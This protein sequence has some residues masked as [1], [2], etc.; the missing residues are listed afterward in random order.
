MLDTLLGFLASQFAPIT[1]GFVL[2]LCTDY[3]IFLIGALG[4]YLLMSAG[5]V[6]L[7]HAALIGAAAYASGVMAVK[8]AVPLWAAMPLAGLVGLLC[9]LIYCVLLGLRLGGFYLAI[10]TFALGE[11]MINI[12]LNTDYLGGALG[13][14]GIPMQSRWP[15]VLPVALAVIFVIWRLENSRF[16]LAFRAIRDHQ[17]V[18]GSMGVDVARMKMTVWM[19]AGFVTGLAGC[20]HAHRV[21]IVTPTEF[22]IYT[23]ITYV[24]AP[25]LGGLRSLWGTVVG[26]AI[27]YFG[28]WL[29]TTDDPRDRLMFYGAMLVALMV[30]R[31]EGLLE[32]RPDRTRPRGWA[33]RF[34]K[35]GDRTSIATPPN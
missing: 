33:K 25:L 17:I 1:P 21:T 34:A 20:L 31:P 12:W 5:Q 8:L 10:G 30:L 14:S 16:G 29:T 24:I 35:R 18:A 26:A 11:M 22:G 32:S 9:G 6:S 23:S 19:V 7:G 28:P 4:L 15:V 13:L 2:D 3:G 27:V